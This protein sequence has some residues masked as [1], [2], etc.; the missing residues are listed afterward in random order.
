MRCSDCWQPFLNS[1]VARSL[2]MRCSDCWQ[3]FLISK[4]HS[5]FLNPALS[6]IFSFPDT[7][8]VRQKNF[9]QR[10][11][12][13][14]LALSPIF[15]FLDTG[16]VRQKNFSQ[17]TKLGKL[18]SKDQTRKMEQWPRNLELG[19]PLTLGKKGADPPG[20]WTQWNLDH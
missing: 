19:P 8:E 5:R 20:S 2:Q 3:P 16:E 1:D 15:S 12:L 7:G 11:K 18:Q 13:L 10:T 17:R 4:N 6:P 9:S 14:N